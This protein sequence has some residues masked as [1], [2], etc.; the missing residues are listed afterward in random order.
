VSVDFGWEATDE[1]HS[2]ILAARLEERCKGSPQRLNI[3]IEKA[4][5]DLRIP[6]PDRP[7]EAEGIGATDLGTPQVAYRFVP[8]ADALKEG[9]L[10][11]N[12]P[13]GWTEDPSPGPKHLIEVT[14]GDNV[15]EDPVAILGL[16]PRIEEVDPCCNDEGRGFQQGFAAV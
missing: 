5:L 4:G 10:G 9:D 8:A 11:G 2:L 1:A 16:L 12:P 13:I 3:D 14:G 15:L 6:M 7:H